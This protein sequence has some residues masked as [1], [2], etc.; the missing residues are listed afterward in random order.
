MAVPKSGTY[1]FSIYALQD[2]HLTKS[3]SGDDILRYRI[4]EDTNYSWKNIT[5]TFKDNILF[6]VDDRGVTHAISYEPDK[7]FGQA[8]YT[9]DS[10]ILESTN[11]PF[12]HYILS[13]EPLDALPSSQ[14]VDYD[15]KS[16]DWTVGPR[17]Y[18]EKY[19]TED[20]FS[21]IVCFLKNARIAVPGGFKLVQ[22]IR[23]GDWVTVAHN[24]F[25][26]ADRVIWAG[27]ARCYVRSS[28]PDDFS[29][30]PVRIRAHAFGPGE[31]THDLLVTA[32]HCI[33]CDGALIPARMLV[34][35][36]SISYEKTLRAYTYYHIETE[37]HAIIEANGLLTESYLDTGNRAAFRN[38]E[39]ETAQ[40]APVKYWHSASAAPLIVARN[41]VEPLFYKLQQ[42]GLQMS[43]SHP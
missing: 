5:V 27:R 7:L 28:L 23:P 39:T 10:V 8:N 32:D 19:S 22:H 30:A 31:P 18:S 21:S 36:I 3:D 40:H 12:R 41:V 34:N 9:H 26:N 15:M 29:G 33:F 1:T 25:R 6:F 43:L 14:V 42:R 4:D 35:G 16:H 13:A 37:E 24:G 17:S 20:A 38:A 11:S 2:G